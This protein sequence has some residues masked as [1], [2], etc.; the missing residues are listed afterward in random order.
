MTKFHNAYSEY[1]RPLSTLHTQNH[2]FSIGKNRPIISNSA[3]DYLDKDCSEKW[4]IYLLIATGTCSAVRT[5]SRRRFSDWRDFTPQFVFVYYSFEFFF[6][7]CYLLC[8][9]ATVIFTIFFN[10]FLFF[11]FFYLAT[12]DFGWQCLQVWSTDTCKYV[13]LLI[14]ETHRLSL[15]T[16]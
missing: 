1:R 16:H 13:M 15:L 14:H 9:V 7:L 12:I 6:I 2:G 4:L 5:C 3:A 8:T 10:Y 11:L